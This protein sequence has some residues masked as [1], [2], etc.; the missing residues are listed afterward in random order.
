MCSRYARKFS[1]DA[2]YISACR[3]KR[4]IGIIVRARSQPSGILITR[5]FVMCIVHPM[6]PHQP[7][8]IERTSVVNDSSGSSSATT[9]ATD[10]C[11]PFER[12]NDEYFFGFFRALVLFLQKPSSVVCSDKPSST[13]ICC[14]ASAQEFPLV[15]VAVE[16]R[17]SGGWRGSDVRESIMNEHT[18]RLVGVS[19]K[20][21]SF[22]I[23]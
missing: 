3:G 8:S 9:I 7:H 18:E 10:H 22:S 15:R 12:H 2:Q 16:G 4:G 6:T 19:L 20:M 11:R 21:D 23:I 5:N 14:V 17:A 13:Y 1:V